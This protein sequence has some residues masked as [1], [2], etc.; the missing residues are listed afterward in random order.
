MIQSFENDLLE[1]MIH[2]WFFCSLVQFFRS[3]V[4]CSYQNAA[5]VTLASP[6]DKSFFCMIQSFA[7]ESMNYLIICTDKSYFIFSTASN[8][9]EKK[10]H[11][12]KDIHTREIGN[13]KRSKSIALCIPTSRVEKRITPLM[14][15]AAVLVIFQKLT[16][17][18]LLWSGYYF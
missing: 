8:E 13:K 9:K 14:S 15:D 7:N 18:L 5:M 12:E 2:D 10:V 16:N 4:I 17:I 3:N 11:S 6:I 1:L